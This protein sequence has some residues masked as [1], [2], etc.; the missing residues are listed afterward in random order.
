MERVC[1]IT[2]A[3]TARLKNDAGGLGNARTRSRSAPVY[4][5]DPAAAL[6][7]GRGP[8]REN[9]LAGEERVLPRELLIWVCYARKR[10]GSCV[11]TAEGGAGQGGSGG[12][13]GEDK[14]KEGR[15]V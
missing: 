15:N 12:D 14:R 3:R 2:R 9:R 7:Q 5:Y 13:L 6:R 8:T 10:R 4:T 11:H 1:A